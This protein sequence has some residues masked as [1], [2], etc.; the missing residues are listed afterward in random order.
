MI[1]NGSVF[2]EDGTFKDLTVI[3]ENGRIKE[4]SEPDASME[5]S[6]TACDASGCFVLP[7]LTDI[8]FHG[9]MGHDFCEGRKEA[10]DVIA[11]FEFSKGV[12]NI[13]PATMTYPP[14]KIDEILI[15]ARDYAKK[16]ERE[17]DDD[18]ARLIGVHL[19]GPFINPEKKGAQ[20][21][22]YITK[23]SYGLLD[24]WLKESDDLVKLVTIAP[25]MDG[26]IECIERMHEG[27][28]FSIG[29]TSS[30]YDTAMRAFKAGADH[31][32]HMFNAC[33]PFSH[34]ATGVIGAAFDDKKVFCELI[35]DGVHVDP[36]AVRMAFRLFG[37]ERMVLVSDSME[38]CGMGDGVFF[39]GGQEVHVQGNKAVL[40]DGTIAGSVTCL[41][42]C[43][44]NAVKMGVE[45]PDAI[46]ATT[47]NPC[48]SIGIDAEY[49]SISVGKRTGFLLLDKKDLSIRGVCK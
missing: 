31:V 28:R 6:S 20:N 17:E 49:G 48:R 23:P 41:Y 9:C 45:L 1:I 30:S 38:A 25:E 19:E 8:H 40:R 3:T 12:T 21:G 4:L 14:E 24:R 37:P 26:A 39:L 43:M 35:C 13:C 33:P 34:R 16:K 5:T 7:G 10:F 47:I 32:T 22:E 29:H 44:I 11:G 36:A 18:N 42:D 46:R 2:T 27:V 15:A